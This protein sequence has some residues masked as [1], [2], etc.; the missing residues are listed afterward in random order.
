M[1]VD[2]GKVAGP[3][4]GC[5]KPVPGDPQP[6]EA[7][8]YNGRRGCLRRRNILRHYDA[9]I[10][11]EGAPVAGGVDRPDGEVEESARCVSRMVEVVLGGDPDQAA[12]A[13]RLALAAAINLVVV[14]VK[15]RG[16]VDI[17]GN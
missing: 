5:G 2:V 9:D 8:R 10:G 12:E 15:D 11:R 7:G 13:G 1:E 3:G 6:A 4:A 17:R 16:A 14:E